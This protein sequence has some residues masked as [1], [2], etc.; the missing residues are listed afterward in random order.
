MYKNTTDTWKFTDLKS[1]YLNK[2]TN[3]SEILIKQYLQTF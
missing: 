3:I 2:Y 1:T